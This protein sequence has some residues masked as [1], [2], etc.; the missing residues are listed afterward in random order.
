VASR[1]GTLGVDG[2]HCY[3]GIRVDSTPIKLDGFSVRLTIPIGTTKGA[4]IAVPVSALSLAADGTS[5]VQVERGG[6]LEYVTVQPGLSV[7]GYVEVTADDGRL[8]PGQLVVVGY[9]MVEPGS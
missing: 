6:N 2:Y 5:R 9:K 1:P 8:T 4:V 3:L 7:G